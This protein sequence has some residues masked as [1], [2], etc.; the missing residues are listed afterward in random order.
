MTLYKCTQCGRADL[1][2]GDLEVNPATG[3]I[4]GCPKCGGKKLEELAPKIL[5]KE[6]GEILKQVWKINWS[7]TDRFGIPGQAGWYEVG[8]SYLSI[9]G[10]KCLLCPSGE[11]LK[12][13][14][15]TKW[16]GT[17]ILIPD[18]ALLAPEAP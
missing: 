2:D 15:T 16:A 5:S 14:G 17:P 7:K 3:N 13:D 4:W 1:N 18:G 8:K 11:W 9:N 12:P 6:N 10:N